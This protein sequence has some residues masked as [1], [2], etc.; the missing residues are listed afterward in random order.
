MSLG[1]SGHVS[2]DAFGVAAQIGFYSIIPI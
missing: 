1:V 2:I